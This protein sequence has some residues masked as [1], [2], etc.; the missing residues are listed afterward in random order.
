M[1]S[2]SRARLLRAATHAQAWGPR[3]PTWIR[4]GGALLQACLFMESNAE[5]DAENLHFMGNFSIYFT[6]ALE[7][8]K[9]KNNKTKAIP[10]IITPGFLWQGQRGLKRLLCCLN[11]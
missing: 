3:Q 7:K 1:P 10:T 2:R 4:D 8:K 5:P 6:L 11:R 9:K